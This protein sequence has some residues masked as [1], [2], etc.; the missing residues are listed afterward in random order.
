MRIAKH[1]PNSTQRLGTI[2]TGHMLVTIDRGDYWQCAYMIPK[3]S[4]EQFKA[5]GIE[6]LQRSIVEVMPAFAIASA[7]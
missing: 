4:F 7:S 6:A 1:P 2:T 3:G 5:Q